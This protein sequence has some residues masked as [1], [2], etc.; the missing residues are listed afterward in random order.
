M[1][2]SCHRERSH[3]ARCSA[4]LRNLDAWNSLD[5]RCG[6]DRATGAR[7]GGG[8]L[9]PPGGKGKGKMLSFSLAGQAIGYTRPLKSPFSLS[10]SCTAASL[11]LNLARISNV[12]EPIARLSRAATSPKN[13]GIDSVQPGYFF[14]CLFCLSCT[15][16]SRK[17]IA[18]PPLRASCRLS[19]SPLLTDFSVIMR[20]LGSLS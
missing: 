17:R 3:F 5:P 8:N 1:C 10:L 2:G 12:F 15:V 20:P 9:P 16:S 4:Q 18:A 14:Q 7:V 6:V 19:T 13:R 11:S